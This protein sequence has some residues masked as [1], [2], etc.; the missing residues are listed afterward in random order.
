MQFRIA[1]KW[2]HIHLYKDPGE[3]YTNVD[4]TLIH[5]FLWI[6]LMLDLT[7]PQ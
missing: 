7:G 1:N 6:L 5:N 2:P 3:T 4:A